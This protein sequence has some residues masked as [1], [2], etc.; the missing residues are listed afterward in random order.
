MAVSE[1]LE[2][3]LELRGIVVAERGLTE[4]GAATDGRERGHASHHIE[5]T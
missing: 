3:L 2:H 5:K 1:R 4:R